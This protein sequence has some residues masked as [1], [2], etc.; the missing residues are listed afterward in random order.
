MTVFEGVLVDIALLVV[1]SLLLLPAFLRGNHKTSNPRI[2]IAIL[3][4]ILFCVYAFWAGDYLHAMERYSQLQAGYDWHFEDV[5]IFIAHNFGVS[6]HTFRLIIWGTT[7]LLITLTYNRLNV[8]WDLTLFFCFTFYL[9]YLSYARVSLA[10]AIMFYGYSLMVKPFNRVRLL[11]P[12]FGAAM[13]CCAV[14][15]H[16]TALFGIAIIF[17]SYL[18]GILSGRWKI[19]ILIALYPL[20]IIIVKFFLADLFIMEMDEDSLLDVD[21]AQIY[22]SSSERRDGWGMIL[23]NY[24]YRIPFY[25]MIFVFIKM[26]FNK[27]YKYVPRDVYAF[28]IV[29]VLIIAS[30]SVFAF[31][32][33]FNTYVFYY[34]FL[35]Y[36]MIPSAV[37]LSYTKSN[38]IEKETM[39]YT[40]LLGI[41]ASSYIIIYRLYQASHL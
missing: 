30:A 9:L 22:M 14:F 39:K 19:F 21:S 4:A 37:F 17:L 32:M 23:Q 10:M 27:K 13:V 5:Y 7:M 2:Y 35:N 38:H 8:R 26:H 24:L 11:S 29:A 28:C 33:G 20:I 3:L 15:F 16:R 6:Y 34:R 12:I 36:A 1:I 40:Y 25:V 18:F 41:V 31:D